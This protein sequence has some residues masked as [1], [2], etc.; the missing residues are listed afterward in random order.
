MLPIG[1]DKALIRCFST[2]NKLQEEEEACCFDR[3]LYG[4]DP[5]VWA[6]LAKFIFCE[7][8]ITEVLCQDM[9]ITMFQLRSF[10]HQRL[11]T[12]A[13]EILGEVEKAIALALSKAE[14]SRRK[15]EAE[16][17]PH[18][19]DFQRKKSGL[20]NFVSTLLYSV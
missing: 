15:E 18:R 10:V 6:R 9:D 2:G 8:T 1:G 5:E 17:P 12:A 16:S 20:S 19:H 14:I 3:W 7:A 4:M 11:Y 13:E